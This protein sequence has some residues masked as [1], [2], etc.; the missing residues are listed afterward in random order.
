MTFASIVGEATKLITSFILW[1]PIFFFVWMV[2]DIIW[3]SGNPEKRKQAGAR[4]TWGIVAMFI[5]ISIGGIIAVLN[6]TFFSSNATITAPPGGG[7]PQSAP[8]APAGTTNGPSSSGGGAGNSG[9]AGN[10]VNFNG[11]LICNSGSPS[12]SS[13]PF[14]SSTSI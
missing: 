14:N 13:N 11:Q 3:T 12:P 7:A 5:F 6:M 4:L 9:G 1:F 8:S 2:A 10:C